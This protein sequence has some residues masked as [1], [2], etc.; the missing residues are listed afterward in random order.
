[1]NQAKL[2]RP[3]PTWPLSVMSDAT[4]ES[5]LSEA[6]DF[7]TPGEPGFVQ[8]LDSLRPGPLLVAV[9]EESFNDPSRHSDA[10]LAAVLRACERL[11]TYVRYQQFLI[12]VELAQ[13]GLA[14][15]TDGA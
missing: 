10:E 14:A 15:S 13:R 2:S 3:A 4:H 9:L 7:A 6:R 5:W 11:I 1:M 8:A 12:I